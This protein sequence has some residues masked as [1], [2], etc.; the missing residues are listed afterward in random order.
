MVPDESVVVTAPSVEEAIIIGLTRLT[1]MR[2]DVDI[3]VLDEGSRGFLSIGAREARV[4]L[5]RRPPQEAATP[6]DASPTPTQEQAAGPAAKRGT[7]RARELAPEEATA[8]PSDVP[9]TKPQRQPQAPIQ[10]KQPQTPEPAAVQTSTPP[11][12][13]LDRPRL[14]QISKE[15]AV[16]LLPEL[17]IE[18]SVEWIDEDRP[19]LWVA[20]E[21][22][23]A[24]ALVGPKGRNLHA[25]QYLFRSL[26][27]RRYDSAYNLVVDAD[28][29]RKRRRRSLESLA[30]QK[31]Q[32]AVDM[33]R[34]IRLRPMPAS[35]RRIV[36]IR[37]REDERVTTESVGRGRQRAVTIIPKRPADG[38]SS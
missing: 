6:A 8:P 1:A 24:G 35:E 30:A 19:T 4:R 34:T 25:I 23:D 31:A 3:E 17:N 26:I 32:A 36:H 10:E 18:V 5:T 9:T 22:G 2:E 12:D 14:E 7:D 37:L 13:D 15:I 16:N 29:Y 33:G 11:A 38:P 20:L 28:G 27:Y 21:G